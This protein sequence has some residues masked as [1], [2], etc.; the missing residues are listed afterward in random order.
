MAKPDASVANV[1]AAV[2][3]ELGATPPNEKPKYTPRYKVIGT[4]VKL[5][6]SNALGKVWKGRIDSAISARKRIGLEQCWDEALRYYNNDQTPHRV[7]A[8]NKAGNVWYARR[9]NEQWTETEN[10]IF[11][12]INAIVPSVY[13]KEPK[14]EFT[15]FDNSNRE[16][17]SVV[18]NVVYALSQQTA[19]PGLNLKEIAKQAVVH[20]LLTNCA[21]VEVGWITK[22]DS[23]TQ[24]LADL[25]TISDQYAKEKDVRKLEDLEGQLMALES[26]V[27][28]LTPS[29][30]FC[31]GYPANRVIVDP[32]AQLPS[33]MDAKWMATEEWY[34]TAFIKAQFGQE[35]GDE[36]VS[37]YNPTHV[38]V[39]D[40]K[41]AESESADNFKL[42]NTG[43]DAAAYGYKSQDAFDKAKYTKC[44]RIWDKTTRRIYLYIDE[45]WEWPLWVYDDKYQ[46]PW[47]FPFFNLAFLTPAVGAWAK[48][49]TTYVLDQQD[50]I[51]DINT[52][53]HRARWAASNKFFYDQQAL[54]REDVEKFLGD[55][56]RQAYP[57]KLQDGKTIDQCLF[58]MPPLSLKFKELFDKG[59]KLQAVNRITGVSVILRNEEFKT[60]TTNQAIQSYE[61]NTQTFLD[62]KLDPLE[63]WLG[64]IYGAVAH[65]CIMNYTPEDVVPF[66]GREQAAQWKQLPADQITNAFRFRVVG[67]T[68]QKP[69][70]SAKKKEALAISQIAGQFGAKSPTVVAMVLRLW[71]NAFDSVEMR[72]EDWDQ[73][74]AEFD[75]SVGGGAAGPTAGGAA[76]AS[77]D[78]ATVIQEAAQLVDGMPPAAKK[79]LGDAMSQGVPMMEAVQMILRSLPQTTPG[80]EPAATPQGA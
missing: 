17:A 4:E 24:A 52:V 2:N 69:T 46:F 44:W 39:G 63:D 62:S 73:L 29:G 71:S 43:G 59:D 68:T 37:L 14:P 66:V 38:L 18:E 67:G 56:K 47:F 10:V 45:R 28:F 41:G 40:L 49:E 36:V 1:D 31:K 9:N 58:A 55:P 61:S 19:A 12:S 5:P 80:P 70:S 16:F 53:M 30:P 64:M 21:W 32:C 6:V 75:A 15:A 50:A 13:A 20:A 8:D 76:P 27:D 72:K 74:R 77:G 65:L 60:N 57:V 25:K 79:A 54:N 35:R 3:A 22:E 51:N 34:P 48:G 23:S 78:P 7:A 33:K 42:F 11:A 26:K